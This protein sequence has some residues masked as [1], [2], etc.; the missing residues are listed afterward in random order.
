MS[1]IIKLDA[2]TTIFL[3]MNYSLLALCKSTQCL[4]YNARNKNYLK[5]ELTKTAV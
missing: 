3:T 4:K 2:T 5:K 1:E